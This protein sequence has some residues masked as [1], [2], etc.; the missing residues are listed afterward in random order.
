MTKISE[1]DIL[2]LKLV[3]IKRYAKAKVE[4]SFSEQLAVRSVGA[5]LTRRAMPV[6]I[7]GVLFELLGET[8]HIILINASAIGALVFYVRDRLKSRHR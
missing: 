6:S 1:Y 7:I 4:I 8:V 3:A 2:I 5:G